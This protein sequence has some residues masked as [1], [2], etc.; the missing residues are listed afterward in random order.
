MKPSSA[1]TAL[2]SL[3]FAFTLQAVAES[4]SNEEGYWPTEKW[5]QAS[6]VSQGFSAQKLNELDKYIEKRLPTATCVLIIRNGFIVTERYYDGLEDTKR[7]VY[8]VTKSVMS[9]LVG[10]AVARN[11]VASIEQP[12]VEIMPSV[13]KES[14][15]P[16]MRSMTIKHLLTMTSGIS[17]TYSESYW[18]VISTEGFARMFRK[19]LEGVPGKK[20]SYNNVNTNLLSMILTEKT[21]LR[22]SE[23]AEKYLF[24]PLGI[25]GYIWGSDDGYTLGTSGLMITARDLAKIGYLI[26]K[27]GQWDGRRMLSEEWIRQAT[28][29][30]TTTNQR[31][32]NEPLGYGYGWW[33]FGSHNFQAIAALGSFGQQLIIVPELALIVVMTGGSLDILRDVILPALENQ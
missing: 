29:V 14:T 21:G 6:A 25:R 24:M 32:E 11:E 12:V 30:Q 3:L 13:F 15:D 19:P 5:S 18:Q 27:K 26:L 22:A 9:C 1:L 2:F 7:A 17:E 23:Y 31:Y 16:Q 33:M 8:S 4:Q 10:I 20:F 28:S